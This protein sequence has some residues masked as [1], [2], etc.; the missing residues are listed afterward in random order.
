MLQPDSRRTIV[1]L[2]T[3][4]GLGC[5]HLA[6]SIYGSSAHISHDGDDPLTRYL[7]GTLLSGDSDLENSVV[8][9]V[10][11]QGKPRRQGSNAT[12]STGKN[13]RR[14]A[15]QYHSLERQAKALSDIFP[16]ARS[17]VVLPLWDSVK[18][19]WFSGGMLWT[20]SP[21]RIFTVEGELSYL[22]A[23]GTTLMG[24]VA[25]LNAQASDKSKSEWFAFTFYSPHRLP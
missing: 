14:E 1:L 5:S 23:F 18:D 19:R 8:V 4:Q 12:A 24:E 21:I 7:D 3:V 17:V 9:S 20:N 25:R 13:K 15:R 10:D 22:R 6:I 2:Q 16:G 11:G